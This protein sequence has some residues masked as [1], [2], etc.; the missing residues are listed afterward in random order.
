MSEIRYI[1]E[2]TNGV[3]TAEIPYTVSDN[4]LLLEQL[5]KETNESHTLVIQAINH[6]GSLTLAQKDQLLKLL[7]KFYIVAGVRLGLFRMGA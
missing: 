4:E 7:A 2:Y 1:R 5:A 6:W 3:L